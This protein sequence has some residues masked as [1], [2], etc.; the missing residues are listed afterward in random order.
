MRRLVRWVALSTRRSDDR[1][2]SVA[3]RT[4]S[5]VGTGFLGSDQNSRGWKPD[6]D[7]PQMLRRPDLPSCR[8]LAAKHHTSR[9]RF[10]HQSVLLVGYVAFNVADSRSEEYTSA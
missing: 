9:R 7:P 5:P 2:R 10:R 4:N 3:S 8:L 1:N 6:H